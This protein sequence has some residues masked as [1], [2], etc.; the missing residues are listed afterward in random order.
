MKAVQSVKSVK[1]ITEAIS[2]GVTLVKKQVK[3]KQMSINT[4]NKTLGLIRLAKQISK[5][6]LDKPSIMC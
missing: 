6:P 1:T 3:S 2:C 4:V 5:K